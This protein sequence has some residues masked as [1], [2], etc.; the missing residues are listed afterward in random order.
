MTDSRGCEHEDT[1]VETASNRLNGVADPEGATI[2]I[3]IIIIRRVPRGKSLT[4]KDIHPTHRTTRPNLQKRART[5]HVA[6]LKRKR[7]LRIHQ[8]TYR[9]PALIPLA[10]TIKVTVRIILLHPPI[11]NIGRR[12]VNTIDE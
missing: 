8:M 3:P 9:H 2:V 10:I 12:N 7:N 1:K 4:R 5:M 6:S 11:R